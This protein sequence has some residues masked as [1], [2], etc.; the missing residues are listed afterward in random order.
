MLSGGTKRRDYRRLVA[1]VKKIFINNNLFLR[2]GIEP[3]NVPLSH[4]TSTYTFY[5]H[6]TLLIRLRI[7][8]VFTSRGVMRR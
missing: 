4:M 3:T 8:I 5:S 6:E 1:R 2:V 7:R